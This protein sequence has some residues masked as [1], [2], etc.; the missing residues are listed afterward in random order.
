[1]IRLWPY[2]KTE[3]DELMGG[4]EAKE[5]AILGERINRTTQNICEH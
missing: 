1:M 2:L 3:P 5:D 4:F